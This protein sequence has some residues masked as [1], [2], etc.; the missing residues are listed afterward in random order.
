MAETSSMHLSFDSPGGACRHVVELRVERDEGSAPTLVL[1][2]GFGDNLHTWKR[3]RS[4]LRGRGARVVAL[5]L[6]GFGATPLPRGFADDYVPSA[7]ALVRA[8]CLAEPGDG[9]VIAVGN[10]MGGSAVLVAAH[11]D[12]GSDERALD[13]AALVAPATLRTAPPPFLALLR[14]PTYRWMGMVADRT[15]RRPW[16]A[17]MRGLVRTVARAALAPGARI[18]PVWVEAVAASL[19][20]P[21]AWGDAEAVARH[22]ARALAGELPALRALEDGPP[23][24][25]P[26]LVLRGARDRV[27]GRAELDA[28]AKRHRDVRRVDLDG[29][30]HCPQLEAPAELA[31]EL[32]ALA[33]RS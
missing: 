23:L 15:P 3:L 24:E 11:L 13:A 18:D 2:H 7:G 25:L 12:A 17:T 30:G 5:D 14:V 6:P 32:L 33:S 26:L 16:L 29:V 19:A 21:G 31:R 27:I 10:S 22:L 4:E 8:A 9:P 28:L 20:R 1:V